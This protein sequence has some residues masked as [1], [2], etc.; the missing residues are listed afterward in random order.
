LKRSIGLGSVAAPLVASLG[1]IAVMTFLQDP[2]SKEEI[3]LEAALVALVVFLLPVSYLATLIFGLPL[4]HVLR[5]Y[6]RLS[7]WWVVLPAAPLGAIAAVGVLSVLVAF[8]DATVQWDKFDWRDVLAFLGGGALYGFVIASVFCLFAGI[9]TNSS[10]AAKAS[11][12][13]SLKIWN[14]RRRVR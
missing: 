8:F 14:S 4:I 10:R 12:A 6:Q 13:V 11:R 7:F 5:R 9:A 3:T 1:Y 2:T